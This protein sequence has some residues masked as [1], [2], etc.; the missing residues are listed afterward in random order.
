[1]ALLCSASKPSPEWV[2]F[3]QPS[4]R[5]FWHRNMKRS[6]K[7]IYIWPNWFGLVRSTILLWSRSV[8]HS[9]MVW[10]PTS[11]W[12]MGIIDQGTLP[13]LLPQSPLQETR[14]KKNLYWGILKSMSNTKQIQNGDYSPGHTS[15][16]LQPSPLKITKYI[17]QQKFTHTDVP[18]IFS[19]KVFLL[20]KLCN[21]LCSCVFF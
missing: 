2:V 20:W 5:T 21:D 9:D 8:Q 6:T 12:S 1:M 10:V 18:N 13:P 3:L 19:S 14:Y 4:S 15:F 17:A 11:A 7:S 16:P